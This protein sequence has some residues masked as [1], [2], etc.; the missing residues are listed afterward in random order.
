M[1]LHKISLLNTLGKRFA[2][3]LS[4]IVCSSPARTPSR[5][6]DAYLNFLMG[7]G[8]GTG[9]DSQQE[10]SAAAARI[11]REKPV[12]FDVGANVGDW[13]KSALETIPQAHIYMFE[14]SPECQLK[15]RGSG[16]SC[17]RLI[18]CAVGA[19]IGTATLHSSSATDGSA[20][21]HARG[22]SYFSDRTYHEITVNVTTIDSMIESENL[23]FVDFVKFDIEGHE[24]FALH[25]ASKAFAAAK[26][27]ALSFEFGSGNINSRTFFR[28]FWNLLTSAGFRI[29]R[30]TPSG[31][32]LL[33]SDYYEDLEYFRGVTNYTAELI[34]HPY[35]TSGLR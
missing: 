13:S 7:K 8:S 6:F 23:S 18:P 19:E 16:L 11:Y 33:V 4:R 22:D 30:I 9:W 24:L 26:I 27:G 10:I 12:I 29:S 21:L 31:S 32:C 2:A 25:G 3:P 17:E 14:P 34:E 28:D 20:S 15:I 1:K 5:A 35:N